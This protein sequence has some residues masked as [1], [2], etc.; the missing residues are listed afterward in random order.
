[1][2]NLDSLFFFFFASLYSKFK[3]PACQCKYPSGTNWHQP[4]CSETLLHRTSA[5][6]H[7]AGSL[8][9]GFET[10]LVCL[11]SLFC[12]ESR[13]P[14]HRQG[15]SKDLRGTPRTN[16]GRYFTLLW[17]LPRQWWT[18]TTLSIY[19]AE[20]WKHFS[21]LPIS[22]TDI[23]EEIVLT[24]EAWSTYTMFHLPVCYRCFFPRASVPKKQSNGPL[25]Q[26][27]STNSPHAPSQLMIECFK[28][29][30]LVE[31]RSGIF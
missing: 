12:W 8:K 20:S 4:Q 2:A 23:S 14:R 31:I 27:T 19:E 29:S 25:L 13:S 11:R 6:P 18:W 5:S 15:E 22:M 3:A 26:K 30:R 28:S 24:V 21:P 9:F 7:W 16:E 1:M 17:G 10:Q